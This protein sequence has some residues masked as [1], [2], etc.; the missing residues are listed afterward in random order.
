MSSL[1]RIE[2]VRYIRPFGSIQANIENV[3][4]PK[5]FV[6]VIVGTSSRKPMLNVNGGVNHGPRTRPGGSI[7]RDS[8]WKVDRDVISKSLGWQS[9]CWLYQ[10]EDYN[11]YN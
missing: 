1:S 10:P 9:N 3:E 6:T 11:D 2:R 7:I 8:R 5:V 4:I